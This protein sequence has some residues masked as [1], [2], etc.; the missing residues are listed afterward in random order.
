ME[1]LSSAIPIILKSLWLSAKWA[2][3]ARMK[4]LKGVASHGEEMVAEV[5]FLRDQA[6]LLETELTLARRQAEEPGRKPRYSLKER[7][8]VLWYLEYFQVPKKQVKKRLG[9]AR[10]RLYRWLKRIDEGGGIEAAPAR[11]KRPATNEAKVM[12]KI[13]RNSKRRPDASR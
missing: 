10:S 11:P 6:V 7:L 5:C 8:L 13:E 1:V 9:V 12:A 4:A 2:G 3:A